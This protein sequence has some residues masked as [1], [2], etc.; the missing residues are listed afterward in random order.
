MEQEAKKLFLENYANK[1]DCKDLPSFIKTFDKEF[2]KA[3]TKKTIRYYP[4]AV[5]ERLFRMQGGVIKVV[6][7]A[8]TVEFKHMDLAPN[9]ETGEL[10][11]KEQESVALFIRL[12]ATWMGITLEEFYPLFD[13]QSAKIIKTPNALDLNTARQRGSVR[14]ISRL[15][16]IG[17]D[18][19]EQQDSQFEDTGEEELNVK[20]K[21]DPKTEATKKEEKTT[22]KASTKKAKDKEK[23][24][25]AM[26]EIVDVKEEEK[27]QPKPE[28][29]QEVEVQNAK[30]EEPEEPEKGFLDAFLKGEEVKD[31]EEVEEI[32]E[33]K[34]GFKEEEFDKE[35]QEYADLLMEVRKI[36]RAG[37][38]QKEAKAFIK[39]QG[40]ELMS[41]LEY[42]EMKGLKSAL[43]KQ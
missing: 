13:N 8:S 42:S 1:G 11:M 38:L 21:E 39:A 29:K 4:W 25:E 22:S 34:K 7:W 14:L 2:K 26:A 32:E 33:K 16:G 35:S 43:E 28:P 18:I 27:P 17:L 9:P 6:D 40:K 36:I 23:K 5:I 24:A 3:G 30:Q 10:V 31:A 37:S 15:S 20:K 19:F 41:Q 12:E